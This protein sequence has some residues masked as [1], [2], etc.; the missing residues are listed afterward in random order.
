MGAGIGDED[1]GGEEEE[2]DPSSDS[3]SR[4][5]VPWSLPPAVKDEY[6]RH[7]E[8]L[9]QT[10]PGSKPRLYETLQTFW[11]PH[12]LNFYS[13]Q[14]QQATPFSALQSPLVL[15]GPRSPC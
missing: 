8:Y 4:P 12:Q 10:P 13:E 1:H 7:L 2:D 5:K 15:L 3:A 11:L 14:V 6:E 9:R